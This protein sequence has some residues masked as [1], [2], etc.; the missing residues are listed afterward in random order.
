MTAASTPSARSLGE[1]MPRWLAEMVSG[2]ALHMAPDDEAAARAAELDEAWSDAIPF[3]YRWA[4]LDD[5]RLAACG[6]IGRFVDTAREMVRASVLPRRITLA[7][8]AGDGK[9]LLGVA[10]LRALSLLRLC[11]PMFVSSPD[12][13]EARIQA[14]AGNGEAPLVVAATGARLVLLDDLGM[15]AATHRD[16]NISVV[17]DR[18]KAGATT[19]VTTGFTMDQLAAKYGDGVARRVFGRSADSGGDVWIVDFRGA[20]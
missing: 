2:K 6:K 7:G 5:P 17:D 16:A 4:S 1:T 20:P 8:D 18:F 14:R 12:L 13:A 15:A 10:I 9:T 3:A 11:R 19:I